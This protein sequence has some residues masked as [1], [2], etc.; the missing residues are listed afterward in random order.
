MPFSAV[1]SFFILTEQQKRTIINGVLQKPNA[2][3]RKGS[4]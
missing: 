1:M 3:I 2:C 4:L